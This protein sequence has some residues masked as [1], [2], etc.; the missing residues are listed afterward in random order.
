MRRSGL[1]G[2]SVF[3][4]VF[5]VFAACSSLNKNADVLSAKRMYAERLVRDSV[6]LRDSIVVRESA[7]TV[8]RTHTRTIY[9]DRLHT[10]TLWRTDTLLMVQESVKPD[11]ERGALLWK[12]MAVLF[13]SALVLWKSGL[14]AFIRRILKK[15]L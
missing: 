11:S 2:F 10:D 9:R 12:N 6:F 4:F 7:D 13:L 5:L 3:I 8:F 1:I 14:L 15:V